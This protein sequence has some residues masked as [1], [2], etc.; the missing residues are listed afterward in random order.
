MVR[1]DGAVRFDQGWGFGITQDKFAQMPEQY[2][3]PRRE[4]GR[5]SEGRTFAFFHVPEADSPGI[6]AYGVIVIESKTSGF[7]ESMHVQYKDSAVV[8]VR[9]IVATMTYD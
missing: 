6:Y 5:T 2:V 9:A 3:W 1:S 7:E 8:E 4:L